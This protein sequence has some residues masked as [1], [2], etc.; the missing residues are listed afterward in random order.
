MIK[1]VATANDKP[2]LFACSDGKEYWIKDQQGRRKRHALINEWIGA[3]IAR[4]LLIPVPDWEAVQ[5]ISDSYD[6][7]IIQPRGRKLTNGVCF[8]S[9]NIQN[10]IDFT[11]Q[12][13][14]LKSKQT[15]D[16][17]TN[18]EDFIRIAILD[19]WI[20][21]GDRNANNYNLI[22]K[23]QPEEL[24]FYAIDHSFMFEDLEY[25]K[26]SNEIDSFQDDTGSLFG[27]NAHQYLLNKIG[28]KKARDV[29]T[30]FFDSINVISEAT[31]R[32][33]F[34]EVPIAWQFSTQEQ[35]YVTEFLLT[36]KNGLHAELKTRNIIR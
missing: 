21:N 7:N 31:L 4:G 13:I 33:L 25:S 16:Q 17:I 22:M 11:D 19:L 12:T 2:I 29:G 28:L 20:A 5:L 30:A 8:G 6:P 35:N 9:N 26:I 3:S 15:F 14:N 34:Q 36:R 10:M 1:Q 24:T 32:T 27:T 23:R 18:P